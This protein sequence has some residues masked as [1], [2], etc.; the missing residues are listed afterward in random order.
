[1]RD[2]LPFKITVVLLGLLSIA[3]VAAAVLLH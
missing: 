2:D 1:M 3:A